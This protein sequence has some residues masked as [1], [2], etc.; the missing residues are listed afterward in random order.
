VQT[1]ADLP[2][3][4][5]RIDRQDPGGEREAR[6]RKAARALKKEEQ[7]YGKSHEELARK[8]PSEAFCAL[9]DHLK[10]NFLGWWWRY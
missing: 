9:D 1:A 3:R 10:P 7:V 5:L 4:S 6:R 2:A 8:H